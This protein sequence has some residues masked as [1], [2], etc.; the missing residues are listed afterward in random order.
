MQGGVGARA[1]DDAGSAVRGIK[2]GEAHIGCSAPPYDIHAAAE[3]ILIRGRHISGRV[4]T[5]VTPDSTGLGRVN[6]RA[7]HFGAEQAGD[8]QGIVTN[9]LCA[10][11]QA[12]RA[13]VPF[14]GGISCLSGRRDAGGLSVG[15]AHHNEFMNA[16]HGPAAFDEFY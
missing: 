2:V 5:H 15:G 14:V 10:H 11:S 3:T 1:A 8:C 6:G 13:G 16:A 12:W 4:P 7:M 9:H